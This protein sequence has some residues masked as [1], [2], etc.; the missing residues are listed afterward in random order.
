MNDGCTVELRIEGKPPPGQEH[1]W[2]WHCIRVEPPQ[3]YKCYTCGLLGDFYNSI[4]RGST[5]YHRLQTCD[6][7]DMMITRGWYGESEATAYDSTG[8]TWQKTYME[9]N[10][11]A[12]SNWNIN[13]RRRQLSKTRRR[14]MLV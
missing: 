11:C 14:R 6:G 13:S 7:N 2:H 12:S 8:L 1:N 9:T 4:D 3:C 5:D 10:N